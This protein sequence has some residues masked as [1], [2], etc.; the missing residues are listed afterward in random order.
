MEAVNHTA[1][2]I[3]M[4]IVFAA[5]IAFDVYLALDSVKANTISARLRAWGKAW[6]PTRLII[7]FGLGVLAGHLWWT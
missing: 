7:T 6:P 3:T 5:I 1:V 4:A 2:A